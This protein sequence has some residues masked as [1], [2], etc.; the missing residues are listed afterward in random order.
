VTILNRI[1][2]SEKMFFTKHL[3]VMLKSGIP[4]SDILETLTA[5]AKS[6]AFREIL[7]KVC[8]DASKG[9]SLEKALSKHPKVFDVFYLSLVRIGEESGTLGESLEFLTEHLE[10]ENNL[11]KKVQ[12]AMLYPSLVL[13]VTGVI[14]VTLAFFVLPQI[15][16]LFEGLDVALPFTTRALI[17]VARI[18]RDYSWAVILGILLSIVIA[19][20]AFRSRKLKPYRDALILRIPLFGYFLGCAAMA[21]LTRNLGV[22][23]RSGLPITSAL[24]TAAATEGNTVYK[25]N[26]EKIAEGVRKGKSIEKALEDGKY[27]EFPPLV[28]KMVGV[29]ERS[30]NLEEN[31]VYLGE[32]FE[33]EVD[34]ITKNMTTILEPILLLLIGSVVAFV[35]LSIVTPIYQITG[36]IR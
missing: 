23:L 8:K 12:S 29:G 2:F 13:A 9:Q 34:G 26:L 20:L 11:R 27:R 16:E 3:A 25:R 30:G 22:M 33:A 36:S 31:L 28:S 19:A 1:S 5:Q 35:A 4:I 14:G 21:N 10:K 18:L 17:F 24:A 32:Y 6:P 7:E 15:T